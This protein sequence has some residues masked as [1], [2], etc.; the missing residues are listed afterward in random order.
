[1]KLST[2][3]R[4][5]YPYNL[6]YTVTNKSSQLGEVKERWGIVPFNG[7]GIDLADYLEATYDGDFYENLEDMAGKDDGYIIN[8]PKR[9]KD[10]EVLRKMKGRPCV[11]VAFFDRL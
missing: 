4:N 9:Y 5:D 6:F 1:M 2:K 11:I 3:I 10:G 8:P 7:P